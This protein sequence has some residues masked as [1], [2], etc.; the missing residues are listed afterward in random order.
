MRILV[1]V[2]DQDLSIRMRALELLSAMVRV[3]LLP[4]CIY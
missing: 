4:S 2:E 3:G 1:S